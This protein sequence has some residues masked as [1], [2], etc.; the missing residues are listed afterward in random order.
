M[1]SFVAFIVL[2]LLLFLV[3]LFG[4]SDNSR[5]G[6][7]P[8]KSVRSFGRSL[9]ITHIHVDSLLTHE[10]CERADEDCPRT[11]EDSRI[12]EGP[13]TIEGSRFTTAHSLVKA[14]SQRLT[15]YILHTLTKAHRHSYSLEKA[16]PLTLSSSGTT[17]AM[18]T[19]LHFLFDRK[20]SIILLVVLSFPTLYNS[21]FRF[22][23]FSFLKLAR[24]R[25]MG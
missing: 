5:Q 23:V 24:R 16:I 20:S 4:S 14:H 18:T 25:A 22:S 3:V 11:N 8:P 17:T 2:R 7:R 15:H 9:I 6:S 10:G 21:S 13:S 12:Q 19:S 1:S